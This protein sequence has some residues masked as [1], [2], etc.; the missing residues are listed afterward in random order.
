MTGVGVVL[1]T[2]PDRLATSARSL[3]D[4]GVDSLWLGEYFQSA[5]ARAAVVASATERVRVGTGVLQAFARS[6]LATALAADDLQEIAGG[7][8]VLGVGSQVPAA[9]RAWHGVETPKP[10][11]MLAEVIDA[12]RALWA[13]PETD[14]VRFEGEHI[15]LDVPGFR[16]PRTQPHPPVFIGGAGTATTDLAA[17]VADGMLGHLFWSYPVAADTVERFGHSAMG[18]RPVTVSRIVAPATVEGSRTDA[19]RRLAHYAVTPAY[20]AVLERAGLDVD[21]AGL[22]EALKRGDDL[23]LE[24][25][26]RDLYATFAITSRDELRDHLDEAG[27]HRVA[28]VIV[29]LP[30]DTGSARRAEAYD[31]ALLDLLDGALG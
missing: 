4:A 28:E 23:R 18:P 8:F 24:S 17:E 1:M 13:A 27:R 15:Q 2:T 26:A 9:N 5:V 10:V 12:M 20:A 6:P 22:L 19:S 31:A 7:R 29:F 21:R 30:Y 11:A 14:R 16:P 25:L 3:E